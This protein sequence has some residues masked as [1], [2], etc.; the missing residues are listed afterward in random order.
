MPQEKAGDLGVVNGSRTSSLNAKVTS[1]EREKFEALAKKRG[2]TVS[3]LAREV[4]VSEIQR[5]GGRARTI[6][7]LSWQVH[8]CRQLIA[9]MTEILVRI[10]RARIAEPKLS[11]HTC[12]EI[13]TEASERFAAKVKQW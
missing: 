6:S 3:A 7:E 11:L 12:D 9:T 1:E 4:L 2:V 13:V 8:E 10:T 5:P